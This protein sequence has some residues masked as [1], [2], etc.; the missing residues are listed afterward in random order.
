VTEHDNLYQ[1]LAERFTAEA[2]Q[3]KPGGK[4]ELIYVTGEMVIARLNEVLGVDGWSFE[5]RNVQPLENEVWALGRL[6]IYDEART[7]VREQ[8]GGQIIGRNRNTGEILELGNDIKGAITDCLK[9]CATLAGVG[10]YLYDQEERREVEADLREARRAPAR[11]PSQTDQKPPKSVHGPNSLPAAPLYPSDAAR[12]TA[13]DRYRGL[14]EV[15]IA[16]GH[17]KAE[18]IKAKP[19]ETLSDEQLH[20]GLAALTRWLETNAPPAALGDWDS[21]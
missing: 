18:Q 3:T 6:T 21:V 8:A 19:V 4:K 2:H 14:A 9:K 13:R 1:R 15:A 17:P 20:A 16:N 12:E 10:L 11:P 5:V 7:V